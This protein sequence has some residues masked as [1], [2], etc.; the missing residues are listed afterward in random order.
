MSGAAAL[1]AIEVG[2]WIAEVGP[3]ECDPI[4]ASGRFV[5]IRMLNDDDDWFVNIRILAT[6]P[7]RSMRSAFA[8]AYMKWYKRIAAAALVEALEG[9]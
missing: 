5:I 3:S 7:P 1:A 8:A 9:V 4:D 2:N 6:R